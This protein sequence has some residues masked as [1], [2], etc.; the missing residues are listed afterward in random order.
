VELVLDRP[1]QRLS[2][3]LARHQR[4]ALADAPPAEVRRLPGMQRNRILMNTSCAWFLTELSA[5]SPGQFLKSPAM[6]IQYL[7]DLGG[8][9]LEPEFVRRLQG[10][11]SNVREYGDGGEVYRRLIQPA[12]V[13]WRRVIAHNAITGLLAEQ[14]DEGRVYAWRIDRVE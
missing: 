8:G 10:A 2:A 13:D 3:W 9:V 14:P 11:P 6:A 12:V 1:P 7:R 5:L 4:A